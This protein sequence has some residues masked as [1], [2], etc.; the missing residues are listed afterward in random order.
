MCRASL[1]AASSSRKALS[2]SAPLVS[3]AVEAVGPM[4]ADRGHQL[5]VELPPDP[6]LVEGDEVGLTQVL[7]NLLNNAAKYT[8]RGGT[9]WITARRDRDRAVV[10]VRDNGPGIPREKLAT[11]FEMFSQVESTLSRAHGGLGIGLFLAKQVVELHHGHIEAHSDGAGPGGRVCRQPALPRRHPGSSRSPR[12]APRL[13]TAARPRRPRH[14][15]ARPRSVRGACLKVAL[16]KSA[17]TRGNSDRDPRNWE[18]Y[19][20][21]GDWIRRVVTAL[22]RP[23]WRAVCL[24]TVWHAC[25]AV[26]KRHVA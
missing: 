4:I 9:I 1:R 5:H 19:F 8:G 3:H 23:K 13:P 11:V 6:L 16:P 25:T 10:S 12:R 21:C 7:S 26:E 18:R 24:D 15:V 17:S 2:T 14:R 20:E 22:S